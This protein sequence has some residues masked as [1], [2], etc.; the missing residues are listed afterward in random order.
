MTDRHPHSPSSGLEWMVACGHVEGAVPGTRAQR[1]AT[2]SN[3]GAF[4]ADL[5]PADAAS[6]P[7][8]AGL[9]RA[10]GDPAHAGERCGSPRTAR[11]T[12]AWRSVTP[13]EATFNRRLGRHYHEGAIVRV[14]APGGLARYLARAAL[15]LE[16]R[17]AMIALLFPGQGEPGPWHAQRR[18]AQLPGLLKR[19][20]ELVGDDPLARVSETADA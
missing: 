3:P 17:P 12:A 18:G 19:C 15:G 5:R 14:R 13:K 6:G 20:A 2:A 7:L 16:R 8:S 11:S 10:M 9:S 1:V 4:D